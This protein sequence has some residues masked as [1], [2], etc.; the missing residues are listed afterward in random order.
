MEVKGSRGE[1]DAR[2]ITR[3]D[4]SLPRYFVLC[5]VLTGP[6]VPIIDSSTVTASVT[7]ATAQS[8]GLTPVE[9]PSL[10]DD[11]DGWS[12]LEDDCPQ[13]YDP[14]QTDLDLDGAG[15]VCDCAAIAPGKTR[16]RS[17]CRRRSMVWTY[18]ARARPPS[19]GP[20]SKRE[21]HDL[22]RS[23][24]RARRPPGGRRLCSSRLP[25]RW[26]FGGDLRRFP[27]APPTPETATTICCAP[28]TPAGSA[29]T[30][31][32]PAHLIPVTS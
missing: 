30:D 12:N 24:R 4:R 9:C 11:A 19:R 23:R 14:P 26:S 13:I 21:R 8:Y 15:D 25:Q 22:R 32:A 5:A 28:R 20:H 27:A 10:D 16:A 17:C 3:P 2:A 31:T 7:S 29:P 18:R 1:F 6:I